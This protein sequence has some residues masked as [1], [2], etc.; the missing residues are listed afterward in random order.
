MGYISAT[1]VGEQPFL[2]VISKVRPVHLFASVYIVDLGFLRHADIGAST[3]LESHSLY[4][5]IRA[6][7][8]I[9]WPRPSMA[10]NMITCAMWLSPRL[11]LP[12]SCL[13]PQ[14]DSASSLGRS[15]AAVFLWMTGS[16]SLRW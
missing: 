1:T 3:H 2:K 7:W 15:T 6:I 8:R 13:L 5:V 4:L 10:M 16:L 14:L 9:Q 12:S 11:A